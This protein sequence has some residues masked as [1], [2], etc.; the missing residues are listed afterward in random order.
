[1]IWLAFYGDYLAEHHE[2]FWKPENIDQRLDACNKIKVLLTETVVMN[3]RILI[4]HKN[5]N[6]CLESSKLSCHG[7]R[8]ELDIDGANFSKSEAHT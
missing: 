3:I 8:L 6:F 4:S 7:I 5:I 2:L 1:M